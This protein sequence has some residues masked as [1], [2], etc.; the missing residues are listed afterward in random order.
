MPRYDGSN[1]D[2]IWAPGA[3]TTINRA[4]LKDVDYA[5][6]SQAQLTQLLAHIPK[7][8]KQSL[9][10]QFARSQWGAAQRDA[11]ATLAKLRALNTAAD[12]VFVEL[13]GRGE[14][15]PEGWFQYF[16]KE[17]VAHIGTELSA[18][19]QTDLETMVR[20]FFAVQGGQIVVG[21]ALRSGGTM[22]GA[23]DFDGWLNAS[24]AHQADFG[25]WLKLLLKAGFTPYS[26]SKPDFLQQRAQGSN[27]SGELAAADNVA[28]AREFVKTPYTWRADTRPIA[29]VAGDGGF[30][31]KADQTKSWSGEHNL[32]ERWNPF[33]DPEINKY[34]WFRKAS[35]D[36]CKYT[37]VSVGIESDW[38]KVI[39]FPRLCDLHGWPA[40]FFAKS[41]GALLPFDKIG[42]EDRK[43]LEKWFSWG[44]F[45]PAQCMIDGK[46][47]SKPVL[48]PAVRTNLY[49][50]ILGGVVINTNKIQG[51][52]AFPEVGVK[53]LKLRNIYG[54]VEVVRFYHGGDDPAGYTAFVVG[55][56]K[57]PNE[58]R[59]KRFKATEKQLDAAFSDLERQLGPMHLAW[60]STGCTTVASGYRYMGKHLQVL[61]YNKTAKPLQC[62]I[63]W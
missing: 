3:T 38:R 41:S 19:E 33:S 39:S 43:Q 53:S 48:L 23:L 8:P 49:L 18:A 1:I 6:V 59:T 11:S 4:L 20:T 56:T 13:R 47:A 22:S 9:D 62:D 46:L 57:V 29:S 40:K 25:R 32:R 35:N 63:L 15:S 44:W 7:G 31:T 30:N 14:F 21:P 16:W 28:L 5:S 26:A 27:P 50:L 17:A 42:V 24:A 60:A 12:P 37:V 34:F 61:G 45:L 55:G 51:A 36:N 2:Q 10:Q 52:G 54:A 58:G